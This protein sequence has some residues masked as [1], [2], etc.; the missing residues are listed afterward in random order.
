MCFF[1]MF[2]SFNVFGENIAY[3]GQN[4]QADFMNL[5]VSDAQISLSV[6]RVRTP[7]CRT[8]WANDSCSFEACR[9]LL[10][11]IAYYSTNLGL[12]NTIQGILASIVIK[13]RPRCPAISFRTIPSPTP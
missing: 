1:S 4:W 3:A 6:L 5:C 10:R 9:A 8:G 12:L 11:A 13:I 7:R 2:L